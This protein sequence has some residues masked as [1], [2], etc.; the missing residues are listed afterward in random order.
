MVHSLPLLDRVAKGVDALRAAAL[1]ADDAVARRVP[2]RQVPAASPIRWAIWRAGW[3]G[4]RRGT[5]LAH[6]PS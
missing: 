4:L 2:R 6:Q 5:S 3:R 1:A